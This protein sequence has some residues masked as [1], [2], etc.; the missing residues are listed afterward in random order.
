M[1]WLGPAGLCGG[2]VGDGRELFFRNDTHLMAV[3]VEPDGEFRASKPRA[4]FSTAGYLADGLHASYAVGPDDQSFYFV[5][6]A[7]GAGTRLVMVLNWFE[8]LKAKMGN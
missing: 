2:V 3:A 6:Q 5:R 4:L 7:S 8:E 1:G